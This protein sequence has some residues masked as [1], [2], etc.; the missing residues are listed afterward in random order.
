VALG[1][2]RVALNTTARLAAVAAAGVA[3]YL[4]V[5]AAALAEPAPGPEIQAGR[6]YWIALAG[7]AAVLAGGMALASR[8]EPRAALLLVLGM[9]ALFRLILVPTPPAL[10]DD[11]Y[12]YLWDGRVQAAGINPYT[13]PPRAPE[14]APL[15]DEAVWPRI[16]RPKEPTIYP[17][18]AQAVFAGAWWLGLRTPATWKILT[19][20]AD[21][22]AMLL[23][24]R[25]LGALGRDRRAVVAYAWNPLPILAFGHSGHIDALVVLGLVAAGL[26]WQAGALRR[27]GLCLGLAAAVKLYPLMALPAFVRGRNGRWSTRRAAAVS[28]LAAGVVAASYLPIA[29]LGAQA[30]GYLSA[31]YLSEEGYTTG[32]RFLLFHALGLDGR[33]LGPLL[34]AAVVIVALRSQRPAPTR[35]AWVLGAVAVVTLT[36]PWYAAPLVALAVA[37][38]AGWA[39]PWL[40]VALET[41]YAGQEIIRATRSSFPFSVPVRVTAAA[42]VVLLALAAIRWGWARRAVIAA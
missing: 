9:G 29:N 5:A 23:I 20:A 7:G 10:S 41:A 28:A 4:G 6:I 35:A 30:F 22:A 37:G 34:L 21:I 8:V 38:G 26:A 16:N 33:L 40:G 11:L 27:L 18:A 24:V 19:V 36:Y 25:L 13:Y 17:P 12:R 14:L 42:V 31:G 3:C 39:W 2:G 32:R 1:Q 15:R